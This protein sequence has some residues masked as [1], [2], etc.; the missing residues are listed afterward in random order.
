MLKGKRGHVFRNQMCLLYSSAL[1][2]Q[3]WHFLMFSV[4]VE[5][6]TVFI[7]S[8]AEFGEHLYNHYFEH[9]QVNYSSPFHGGFF[10]RFYL[11][12]MFGT[13]AFVSSLCL[14]DSLW[15]LFCMR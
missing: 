13:Y 10:L 9:F 3:V 4:F 15:W 6:F 14:T 1:C 11:I 5:A 12:L 8:S 7:L 2:L